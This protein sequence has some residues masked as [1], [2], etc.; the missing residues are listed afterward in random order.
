MSNTAFRT[1]IP[2]INE[3]EGSIASDHV[4]RSFVPTICDQMLGIV[5]PHEDPDFMDGIM[6]DGQQGLVDM[7]AFDESIILADPEDLIAF[8]HVFNDDVAD[9]NPTVWSI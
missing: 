8:N 7:S 1:T 5:S 4:G 6:Y 2:T 9:V 3:I